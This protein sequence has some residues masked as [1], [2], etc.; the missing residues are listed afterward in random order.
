MESGVSLLTRQPTRLPSGSASTKLPLP[1]GTWR[2]AAAFVFLAAAVLAGVARLSGNTG[3]NGV[4]QSAVGSSLAVATD[5]SD[6]NPCTQAEPC[7]TFDHAYHVAQAGQVVEVAAGRYPDQALTADPAKTSRS[8]VVF[9]PAAGAAVIVGS[10]P[11]AQRLRGGVGIDVTGAKHVTFKDMT[12]RGDVQA[13]GGAEDVTFDNLVS[14]NGMP[15]VSAPTR[16][17]TIRGGAYGNTLRYFLQVYPSANGTHNYNFTIDGTALHDVRSDDLNA[18]HVACML[19]SDAIGAVVRNLHTSNCEVF[20]VELGVFSDGRLSNVLVENNFFTG[21]GSNVNS[22][23]ALNTNTKRWHGL[24]VRNN[25]ALVPIRHPDCSEGCTNV[26]YSGNISPLPGFY[27]MACER[28]VIYRHNVWTGGTR[29]CSATDI[30]VSRVAF[31]RSTGLARDLHLAKGS[32]AIGRGDP[33]NAPATDID[34]Q[35]RPRKRAVD[36]GAD[37]R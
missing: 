17:I 30:A 2:W 26:R 3:G 29:R 1:A 11:L 9:R 23:L 34:G 4:A 33:L 37:Q 6:D 32:I 20:E 7:L 18:Y 15:G 24:N 5:G 36:A 31:V 12:V 14:H 21:T 28:G 8:D 22:S 19:I 10:K 35:L 27:P 25:T 13:S 16:N